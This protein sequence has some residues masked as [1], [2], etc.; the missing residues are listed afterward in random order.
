MTKQIIQYTFLKTKVC[1]QYK[2]FVKPNLNYEDIIYNKPLNN[3]F[4]REIKIVQLNAAVVRTGTIKEIFFDKTYQEHGLKFFA[5][6][7]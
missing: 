1:K 7:R 2:N 5:D 4:R 3:F 6:R